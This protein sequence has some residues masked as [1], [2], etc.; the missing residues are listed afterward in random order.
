MAGGTMLTYLKTL[1]DADAMTL[2]FVGTEG[3]APVLHEGISGKTAAYWATDNSNALFDGGG[4]L[5]IAGY[6]S[7]N[8]LSMAAS[9]WVFLNLGINDV[10]SQSTDTGADSVAT[11][12]SAHY[13]TLITAF[14]AYEAAL[15][16]AISIPIPPT[17]QQ[18]AFGSNYLSSQTS[19]RQKANMLRL[20]KKLI[21]DF[22]GREGE[23]IYLCPINMGI[24]PKWGFPYTTESASSRSSEQIMRWT[25]GVHPNASGY[26][27]IADQLFAFLKYHQ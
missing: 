3:I 11:S 13:E 21:T 1:F 18:D 16:F 14:Q 7:S 22:S 2:A 8:G 27:Q 5:N 19:L 4:S 6:M 23:G 17:S 25:N 10:F 24:D 9:D 12:M 15:R 20:A 26:G